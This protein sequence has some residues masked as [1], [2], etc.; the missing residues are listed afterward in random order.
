MLFM[1]F[2][3]VVVFVTPAIAQL[4]LDRWIYLTAQVAHKVGIIFALDVYMQACGYVHTQVHSD[5]VYER[6]EELGRGG[7]ESN[8][9]YRLKAIKI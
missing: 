2:I 7:G 1:S 3:A 6:V 9:E 4:V 5:L 8:N